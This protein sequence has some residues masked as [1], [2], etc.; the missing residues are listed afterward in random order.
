MSYPQQPHQPPQQPPPYMPP[1]A[2][3]PR[4]PK[5]WPWILGI[6][7]ALLLGIII[8]NAG[9]PNSGSN[10]ARETVTVRVPA[11]A[12]TG[13]ETAPAP[14]QAG[15]ATSMGNGTYQVGVDVQP[16]QYKT[17]GPE[18]SLPCYWA[19]LKD[20]SGQFDAIIANGTP[21]GPGSVT[22]NDGEF[23][24]LSGGCTWNKVG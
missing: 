13:A 5:R 16:G 11:D 15:P 9:N 4:K 21:Q 10:S 14:A 17:A 6:I 1:P 8:G 2:A 23:V 7:G 12:A 3:A 20:D 22:I 24:E 18:S 19:R